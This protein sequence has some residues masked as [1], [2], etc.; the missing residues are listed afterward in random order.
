MEVDQV[1][2]T[3]CLVS[4]LQGGLW[5]TVKIMQD[6]PEKGLD[7]KL[8]CVHYPMHPTSRSCLFFMYNNIWY[9]SLRAWRKNTINQFK[10]LV[11]FYPITAERGEG[12]ITQKVLVL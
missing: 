1:L 9:V 11:C 7:H 4:L 3:L 5:K 12:G 8:P 6:I 2:S 10:V